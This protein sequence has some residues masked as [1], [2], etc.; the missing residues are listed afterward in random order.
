MTTRQEALCPVASEIITYVTVRG[1]SILLTSHLPTRAAG[2]P[3]TARAETA[4]AAPRAKPPLCLLFSRFAPLL[5]GPEPGPPGP[6][7][8]LLPHDVPSN[9]IVGH[10]SDEIILRQNEKFGV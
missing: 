4:E 7:P 3:L 2:E 1:Q 10:L 5:G 6:L 8:T 9:Y